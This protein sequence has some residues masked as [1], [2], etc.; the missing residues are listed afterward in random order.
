[1]SRSFI[2][3]F[4]VLIQLTDLL[5]QPCN[6]SYRYAVVIKNAA[7]QDA[8]WKSVADTLLKIHGKSAAQLFQWNASVTEVKAGL[9]QFMPDYIAYVCRPVTDVS[10]TFIKTLLNFNRELD[11]DPYFD[12]VW[13]IV[14]GYVAQDAI[15]AVTSKVRCKTTVV[16]P[17]GV[18]VKTRQGVQF[19]VDPPNV[20]YWF[21]DG[22]S[23]Q[24]NDPSNIGT[25]RIVPICKWLNEGI[26]IEMTGHPA[27]DGPIDMFITGGHGNINQWQAHFPTS[28]SEGFLK[29]SNGQLYGDPYTGSN[30]NIN[31]TTPTVYF[32]IN[33]CLIGC[34]DNI[35]NMV[36][37]WFHTGGA[38]HLF[39]YIV[40][41]WASHVGYS[42]FSRMTDKINPSE[43]YFLAMNN[44]KFSCEKDI[45]FSTWKEN[46]FVFNL[47]NTIMYGD[48][49][50]DAFF[51]T[52]YYSN[53]NDVINKITLIKTTPQQPDTFVY[54]STW[55]TDT[56]KAYEWWHRDFRPVM[57]L[58][59]RIDPATVTIIKN[60]LHTQVICDNI[61]LADPWRDTECTIGAK[62]TLIWT[63]KV[64]NNPTDVKIPVAESLRKAQLKVVCLPNTNTISVHYPL[65]VRGNLILTI[66]NASGRA[67]VRKLYNRAGTDMSE[68]SI[69]INM[70]NGDAFLTAGMYYAI[71]R[72]GST[73]LQDKFVYVR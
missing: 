1:M 5:S 68:R 53:E 16:G 50:G 4:V 6:D 46:E 38:M 64:I 61:L 3:C 13:S 69:T 67:V 47:E 10:N 36:Y 71:L 43:A 14:T 25:D 56:Y 60:E 41:T 70:K 32:A 24:T 8:D 20:T 51:D 62:K 30:I 42:T 48:P 33:N 31:K 29:S 26:H 21:P 34:P 54:T 66:F 59:A 49:K 15:R 52:S 39:G 7:Y 73:I 17:D 44:L 27:I 9:A 12:A 65:R 28:G 45:M 58:P 11:T 23:Q 18:G 37:A 2:L 19:P 35:G 22:F 72:C 57:C 55:N 63:A 40:E